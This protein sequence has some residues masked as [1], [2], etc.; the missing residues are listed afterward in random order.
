MASRF[1]IEAVFKAIDRMSAPVKRMNASIEKFSKGLGQVEKTTDKVSSG[2]KKMGAAA[3][4]AAA[5]TAAAIV[6]IVK[7]GA[8]FDRTLVGAAAKFD[9]AIKRGTEGF[10]KL[11]RAAEDIGERTEFNAQ[12]GAEALKSLASAGFSVEQAI[13]ALPGVV[14]L[15]T[16]SEVDLGTATEMATKALGAFGL[17]ADDATQLGKNLTRVNDVM[18]FTANKTSASMEGLFESI[19]EG[20]PVAV[21]AGASMETFMAMA[22]KLSEAGIEGSV[23]G[24]TLKNV[25][26]S[27]SAP[28]KRAA[29]M[30]RKLRV[31]TR[32]ANGNARDA[33]AVFADLEKA[34]AGLGTAART[35]AL[36][37]I[38]GREA[39][40]GASKLLEVGAPAIEA[41]R[42]QLEA[43]EGATS[44]MAEAMRDTVAGDLDELSSSIDGVKISIFSMNNGPIRDVIQG[45]TAWVQANKGLITQRV[46]DTVKW[47]AANLADIVKWV[48]RIAVGVATF[49]AISTAVKVAHVALEAYLLTT[50]VLGVLNVALAGTVRATTVAIR[51]STVAMG[52][53]NAEAAAG[54]TGLAGLRAGLNAS[55]LGTAINGVTSALGAAGLLGAALAVGVAFGMWLDHTFKLSDKLADILA[56]ITGINK[57]LDAAGGRASKRG[58]TPGVDQ[59][60]ADGTIISAA[61]K[62]IRKGTQWQKHAD[63]LVDRLTAPSR[64]DNM[65]TLPGAVESS[66]RANSTWRRDRPEQ[67][68]LRFNREDW[69]NSVVSPQERVAREISETV[70]TDRSEVTIKDET[71]RAEV[72]KKPRAG[73]LKL[74][75]TGAL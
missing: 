64:L 43:A 30:L 1:S 24:T 22:G 45:M 25:F 12:Q 56:D 36:E 46:Q 62:L 15:A 28:T 14:D 70:N 20:A 61:G 41:L 66:E 48:K 21:A 53:F 8:E 13:A 71:G 5:L 31:S 58:I 4:A 18:A 69:R 67:D 17:K 27:L 42:K 11:R 34:T 51:A 6:D 32:D 74:Q 57:G 10:E 9:P 65:S 47:V 44:K 50:K 59:V 19:K 60:Y 40:A 72:T 39:V 55:K 37:K 49:Y 7:T 2:L 23:A 33:V 3:T 54:A 75:P 38:F 68:L 16:A 52:L 63:K 73:N 26:L 29:D 35:N